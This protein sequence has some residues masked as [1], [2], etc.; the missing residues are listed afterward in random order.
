VQAVHGHRAQ[1]RGGHD[2]GI[3]DDPLYQRNRTVVL[4]QEP[5][6]PGYPAGIHG[7]KRVRT[8]TAD[9]RIPVV[10]GGTH[11]RANLRGLCG[12]CNSRKGADEARSRGEAPSRQGSRDGAP[13]RVWRE[14]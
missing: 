6:C 13:G 12:P 9:H 14:V 8:T 11:D 1:R 7:T 10:E 4:R 2:A 5:W 3:Y